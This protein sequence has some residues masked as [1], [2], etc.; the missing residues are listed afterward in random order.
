[1]IERILQGEGGFWVQAVT[2]DH[3]GGKIEFVVPDHPLRGGE[4]LT[5]G[6]IEIKV[7]HFPDRAIN[8]YQQRRSI[9]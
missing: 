5:L 1:M 4:T 8:P 2:D 3:D 9:S 7:R 6:G